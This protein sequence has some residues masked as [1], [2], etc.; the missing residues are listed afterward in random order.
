M[1]P[2]FLTDDA[3]NLSYAETK[4]GQIYSNSANDEKR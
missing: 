4:E 1:A 3:N 2:A